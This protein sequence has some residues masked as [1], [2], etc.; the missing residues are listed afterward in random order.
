MITSLAAVMETLLA[1]TSRSRIMRAPEATQQK[2]DR[3]RNIMGL[4]A[5]LEFTLTPLPKVISAPFAQ[6]MRGR[7]RKITD[8][9]IPR[10]RLAFA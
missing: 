10:A 6:R 9:W 5:S 2:V 3:S 8:L 7:P 4:E 1:P